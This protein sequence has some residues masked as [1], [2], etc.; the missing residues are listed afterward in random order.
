MPGVCFQNITNWFTPSGANGASATAQWH[1]N[2]A[3]TSWTWNG[4]VHYLNRPNEWI[5][6][7]F[8]ANYVMAN[9]VIYDSIPFRIVDRTISRW[10]MI[11]CPISGSPTT[12]SVW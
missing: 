10:K 2:P 9:I 6:S 5:A 12:P 8:N 4:L 3:D 1:Y 7:D 11:Q